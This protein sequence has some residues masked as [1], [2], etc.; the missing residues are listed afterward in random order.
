MSVY[1]SGG[2]CHTVI[3]CLR[4]APLC[5]RLKPLHCGFAH[6]ECVLFFFFCL[7]LTV[8]T[9]EERRRRRA[10]FLV[11]CGCRVDSWHLQPLVASM[12][13]A[14][15]CTEDAF[16]SALVNCGNVGGALDRPFNLFFFFCKH[17]GSGNGLCVHVCVCASAF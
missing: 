13:S 12:L 11:K 15:P 1:H 2:R 3:V 5:L 7:Y 17:S 9:W 6:I 4:F 16:V 8:G 10:L 14:E